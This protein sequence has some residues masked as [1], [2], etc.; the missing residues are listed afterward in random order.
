MKLNGFMV[1]MLALAAGSATPVAAQ[2]PST[3]VT[4]ADIQRLQDDIYNVSRDLS[5]VRSRDDATA[6]Q[7]Q[8]ELDDA[9]DEAI[10]LK[11]KLRTNQPIPRREFTEVRDRIESIRARARSAS[12]DAR[13]DN[14]SDTPALPPAGL[15]ART[16]PTRA[17]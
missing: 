2:A 5:D 12:V 9:R 8:A 13:R 17:P 4:S 16:A 1:L 3:S 14:G 10:Y 7:L 6:S 11:V 15:P